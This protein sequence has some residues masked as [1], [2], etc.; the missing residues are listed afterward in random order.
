MITKLPDIHCPLTPAVAAEHASLQQIDGDRKLSTSR[1][2][3]LK[4]RVEKGLFHSPDWAVAYYGGA[5]LRI[6]GKHSSTMLAGM[7]GEFPHG[8]SVTIKQFQCDAPADLAT[9]FDQFDAPQSARSKNDSTNVH[10]HLHDELKGISTTNVNVAIAGVVWL[11][12]ET[13]GAFF[14]AEDMRQLVHQETEFITD[15]NIYAGTRRLKRPGIMAAMY[16]TRGNNREEWSAFWNAVRD[17]SHEDS[18][19]GSR[20]LGKFL[21]LSMYNPLEPGTKTKWDTR[22]YYCKCVHGWNAA[23]SSLSTDLKYHKG[24][25]LPKVR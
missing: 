23:K 14:T 21:E 18:K 6:N 15:V 19:N 8:L 2:R 13:S 10:K 3:F 24:A 17:Q 9:L 22:A 7:N 4:D 1:T 20:V 12:R 16:A 11:L 25:P 5:K